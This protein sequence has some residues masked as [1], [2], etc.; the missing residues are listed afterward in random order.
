NGEPATERLYRAQWTSPEIS[1]NK[2][3]RL[4][5]KASAA[6][7]LVAVL[8]LNS[9]W[10]CHRCGGRGDFLMM[11]NAG[12]SCLHCVGLDDL[13]FLPA[14]EALL[15]RRAKA[16]SARHAVVVRFSKSRGR[17]ERQGLLVEPQALAETRRELEEQGRLARS[18]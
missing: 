16:R 5:E 7:E 8:P 2:R 11:E 10:T 1:D 3:E 6:P 18:R 15:T 13:E 17:Y 12:P 14:G 4:V 9:E